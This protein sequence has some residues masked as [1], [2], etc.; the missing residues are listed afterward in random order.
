MAFVAAV[1]LAGLAT[2]STGCFGRTET[3]NEACERSYVLF[4]RLRS[5]I[6]KACLSFDIG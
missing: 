5:D 2:L 6:G 4:S 1:L 3:E